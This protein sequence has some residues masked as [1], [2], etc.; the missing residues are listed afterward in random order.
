MFG[1][2]DFPK[3]QETYRNRSDTKTIHIIVVRERVQLLYI[4]ER[5]TK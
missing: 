5:K 1:K 4:D 2:P 3:L